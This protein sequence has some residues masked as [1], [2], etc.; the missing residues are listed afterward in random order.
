MSTLFLILLSTS[1][2]ALVVLVPMVII[3]MLKKKK[4]NTLYRS[5][6]ITILVTFISIMGFIFTIEETKISDQTEKVES[7]I[8][9]E[10]KK[11][12]PAINMV[13]ANDTSLPLGERIKKIAEDLFGDTTVQ[14]TERNITIDNIGELYY[15]NLMIDDGITKKNTLALAQRHTV[16][17]LKVLQSVDD[18]KQ[19]NINWQGNF[20]DSIGN[21]NVG[22]AMNVM[23]KKE[24]IK[25][26]NFDEF[27]A[28]KLKE[29]AVNYGVHNSF[30]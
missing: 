14:G 10:P 19:I 26:V 24:N 16:E 2:V 23:V 9:E 8:Q 3:D 27:D 30:K 1:L 12:T 21:S 28:N 7:E 22:S 29:I 17:L 4:S 6:G 15:L 20:K 18:F 13:N 11:A 5:T 25:N